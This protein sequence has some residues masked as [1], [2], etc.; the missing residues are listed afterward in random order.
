M[1]SISIHALTSTIKIKDPNGADLS[2]C[3]YEMDNIAQGSSVGFIYHQVLIDQNSDDD[4]QDSYLNLVRDIEVK[5]NI[6]ESA[7][8][9]ELLVELLILK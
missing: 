8:R 3:E 6:G 9:L 5:E 7:P 2:T 4:A 1:V